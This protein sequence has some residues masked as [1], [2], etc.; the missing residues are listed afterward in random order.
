MYYKLKL[1]NGVSL[2]TDPCNGNEVI[3]INTTF[4]GKEGNASLDSTD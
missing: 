1:L 3:Q 4:F 2:K